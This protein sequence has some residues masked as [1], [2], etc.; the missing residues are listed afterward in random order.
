MQRRRLVRARDLAAFRR[1]LVE[2][3]LSGPPLDARRRV[4]IVPTSAAAE[5]L[6]QTIERHAVERGQAAVLLPDLL[7]R[8]QWTGRLATAIAGVAV[9]SRIEREV[10]FERAAK[11]AR[12]A[13]PAGSDLFELRPGLVGAMLDFYDELR[14]RQ[15]VPRR[16]VR[17]L[18]AE[19]GVERGMDRGSEHLIR[20]TCVLGFTFLAYA[21]RMASL[22]VLDEHALRDR[23]I[24][25][26]PLLPFDHVVVAVAD[27]PSDPRGLWP[28]DF[29]LLGRLGALD[30]VDVVVTDEV[31]DAGFRERLEHELPGIEEVRAADGPHRGRLLRPSGPSSKP[32]VFVYRDREEE[33]RGV[34]REIRGRADSTGGHLVESTAIV[35]QRPLPYLYLAAQV[36]DDARVPYQAFDAMPLA[37]EPYAALVDLV[38]DVARTGGTR[39][40]VVALLGSPLLAFDDVT[41]GDVAA[42][43]AV[44]AERRTAGDATSYSAEVDAYFRSGRRRI[45]EDA[46]KRAAQAA[47]AT[48]GALR[49]YGGAE[50]AADQI[51]TIVRFV[52]RHERLPGPADAWGERFLRGRRG[53]LGVLDELARSFRRHDD[54][55]RDSDLITAAIRH[56]IEGR[57]FTPRRGSAGVHLVDAVAARFG[58]FAHVSLVGLVE[59]DWLERARRT[60]FY[61][62]T[63]L[64]ALGWPQEPDRMRAEVANFQDLLGLASETTR[65]TAFQLEGEA[66]VSFSPLVERT[67]GLPTVEV[68]PVPHR[69]LF[70]DE[71]LTTDDVPAALDA[72]RAAWLAVRRNRPPLS[73]PRYSGFVDAQAPRPYRVSRVDRYV[74]CPFKYFSESV[75]QLTE[76]RDEPAGLTPLERGTL[77]HALFEDFYRAWQAERRGAITPETLPEAVQRFGTIAREAFARL[78]EPDRRLEETRLLGSIVGTGVAERVFEL[79]ADS[80]LPVRER[81]L[82]SELNGAF[83]FPILNGLSERSIAIRGKADRIDILDDGSVRVVDYKLG[84]M[85]DLATSI[86]IAVYAHCT[87]QL[88]EAADGRQHPIRSAAYLAFGDDR[89]LEGTLGSSQEP[90]PI[91]VEV[92]ASAFAATVGRIEAG[93]FPPRPKR[94]GDCRWCGYQ[95]V[96][97]KEYLAE[98]DETT[99]AV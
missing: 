23:L 20:Q 86:Q 80:G 7:T 14:R 74:D 37:A 79:E 17:A 41:G 78:P 97:R 62:A 87:R 57:T 93:E 2:L 64:K 28:A 53:V 45:P 63:L 22:G 68:D 3:A 55:P 83:R 47:S 92:R 85:P 29:D 50:S 27:H 46:A 69:P 25:A 19:L 40:T 51:E 26:Q 21:R 65:L 82:E 35:F 61:P 16:F 99:D 44:L 67:R 42:L 91:A 36:L 84:R 52:R 10:M 43:D 8:E 75:L 58:A 34:V 66:I 12:L 98:D 24:A 13:H 32:P 48:A 31:H 56:A 76:E 15:R 30:R 9:A 73:D 11:D 72:D 90:P 77:L 5:L 94:P 70:T 38:L 49:S 71:L 81:R 60:V 39:E 4:V 88:L 33:L 6:R 59:T 1:A 96:C 89:R 95:G 54:R 18:F